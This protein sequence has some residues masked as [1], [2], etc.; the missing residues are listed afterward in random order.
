MRIWHL[1]YPERGKLMVV[2]PWS[3]L[4]STTGKVA[5]SLKAVHQNAIWS[6]VY[7]HDAVGMVFGAV[8][9]YH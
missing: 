5:I 7:Q 9:C 6:R 1:E 4:L 8:A 2:S 3:W